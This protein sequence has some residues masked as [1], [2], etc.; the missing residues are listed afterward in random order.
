MDFCLIF[1]RIDTNNI[2]YHEPLHYPP[3][4]F[5][6]ESTKL[7]TFI[8][9]LVPEIFFCTFFDEILGASNISS[10]IR[11]AKQKSDISMFG[12]LFEQ[13]TP[14][15]LVYALA[16][17]LLSSNVKFSAGFPVNELKYAN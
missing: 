10:K 3:P 11:C 17:P 6:Y 16:L 5:Y 1:T 4:S 8:N 14:R 9:P 7:I 2:H 12:A 15:R 13:K